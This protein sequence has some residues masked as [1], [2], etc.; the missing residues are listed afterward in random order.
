[1]YLLTLWE[2]QSGIKVQKNNQNRF[3]VYS[4]QY[5]KL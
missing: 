1:M 5:S 3:L 2:L 4:A